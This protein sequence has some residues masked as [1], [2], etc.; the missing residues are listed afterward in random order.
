MIDLDKLILESEYNAFKNVNSYPG[1]ITFPASVPPATLATPF[2]S[3]ST[4]VQL[5]DVPVFTM[6]FAKFTE[7]FDGLLGAVN[8]QWYPIS[9]ANGPGYGGVAYYD[10]A[11][12]GA[13]LPGVLYQTINGSVITITATVFNATAHTY[14]ANLTV[15][16]VFVEYT[17][18][19]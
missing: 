15:P 9:V 5:I 1:S 17:L 4:T 12:G 8:P 13:A 3:T 7:L 2:T 6:M 14:V 11:F 16:F 19:N 18:A 10:I